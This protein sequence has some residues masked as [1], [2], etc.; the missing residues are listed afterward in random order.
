MKKTLNFLFLFF[1]FCLSNVFGMEYEQPTN[2]I[3]RS[4]KIGFNP[5][6]APVPLMRERFADSTEVDYD[7]LEKYIHYSFQDRKLL[8]DAL[9]PLLPKDA[10][11]S[12]QKFDHLEFLGDSVLGLV[13]RERLLLLFPEERRHN[14]TQ[15]YNSITENQTLTDIFLT[16]LDIERYLPFPEQEDCIICNVVESLIGAIYQ[17][18]LENG[19]ANSRKFIMR[20]LDDHILRG[21]IEEFSERGGSKL[22]MDIPPQQQEVISKTCTPEK[23]ASENPKSLLNEVLIR[24][25]NDKPTYGVSIKEKD[26]FPRFLATVFG[27]QIGKIQGEGD[28]RQE[29]KEDAAR[30]ALNFLAGRE[31][32]PKKDMG[33]SSKNFRSRLEE[34]L[35]ISRPGYKLVDVTPPIKAQVKVKGVVVGEGIGGSVEEAKEAA[36]QEACHYLKKPFVFPEDKDQGLKTYG[37]LLMEFF[38]RAQHNDC[39]FI[40]EPSQDGFRCQIE[41]EKKIVGIGVGVSKAKAKE[42]ASKDAFLFLRTQE[43]F[44]NYSPLLRLFLMLDG[45][46]GC[47]FSICQSFKFQVKDGDTILGEAV[48][49]SKDEAKE[50]AACNA[51]FQLIEEEEAK[52]EGREGLQE[53]LRLLAFEHKVLASE[54]KVPASKRGKKVSK[55]G[56]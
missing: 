38:Q 35:R 24:L 22:N 32:L 52:A 12:E 3:A 20:I 19:L 37:V 44:A 49:D 34:Y 40:S 6:K 1:I 11:S 14:I 53:M 42:Q 17:D 5:N 4:V 9:H 48:G 56:K 55:R 36:A 51:Y 7:G 26:G 25:W 10:Q 13:I 41:I 28:T 18:D 47:E 43:E 27:A 39:E 8:R 54:H 15:L 2:R 16:N 33:I 50:H 30:N 31:L 46:D 21:K 45:L 23:L 29:S